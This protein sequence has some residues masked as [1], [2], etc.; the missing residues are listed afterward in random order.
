MR[1][2]TVGLCLEYSRETQ[3]ED[4]LSEITYMRMLK[5]VE[6][7]IR[8]SMKGLDNYAADGAQGFDDLRDSATTIGHVFKVHEWTENMKKKLHDGNIY[9]KL[10]YKVRLTLFI[11]IIEIV[12]SP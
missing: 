8:K 4:V 2:R 12:L 5:A 11:L 10:Q 6:P 1:T 7:N 3:C 9:F